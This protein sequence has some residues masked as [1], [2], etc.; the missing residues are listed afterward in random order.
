M[1]I[2]SEQ[3]ANSVLAELQRDGFVVPIGDHLEPSL[4]GSALAQATAAKPLL[5]STAER[6][7][8]TVVERAK[9]INADDDWPY[10][11]TMLV[12]FGSFVGE[13]ERPNDVDV[14]CKL[15]PRWEGEAQPWPSTLEG[16]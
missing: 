7:V 9:A 3:T 11:V 2:C 8:S 6:L 12:V 16:F 15:E 10:R 14:A 1:A 13:A 5:R 4:E